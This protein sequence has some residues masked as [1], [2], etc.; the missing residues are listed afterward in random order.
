MLSARSPGR[1]CLCTRS[2]TGIRKAL[3]VLFGRFRPTFPEM[4]TLEFGVEVVADNI[5]AVELALGVNETDGVVD[6]LPLYRQ[7]V[8]IQLE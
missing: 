8:S 5:L 7:P 3:K 2:G 6:L 1:S 4:G